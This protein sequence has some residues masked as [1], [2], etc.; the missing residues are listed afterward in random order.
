MQSISMAGLP[1]LS[2]TFFGLRHV[3]G[4]FVAVV[5]L[6]FYAIWPVFLLIWLH[7]GGIRRQI[8]EWG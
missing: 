5:M 3:F 1:G 7:R 6:L 8:A 2:Q 4:G